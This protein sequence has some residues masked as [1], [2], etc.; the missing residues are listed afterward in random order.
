M[1]AAVRSIDHQPC[2]LTANSFITTSDRSPG[3]GTAGAERAIDRVLQLQPAAIDVVGDVHDFDHAARRADEGETLRSP[4]STCR[5]RCGWKAMP[6]PLSNESYL[7][8][9]RRWN[10]SLTAAKNDCE[11]CDATV[12][13]VRS[14]AKPNTCS[15]ALS[16]RSEIVTSGEKKFGTGPVGVGHHDRRGR[17]QSC[18]L[19]RTRPSSDC[20]WRPRRSCRSAASVATSRRS[21]ASASLP[22]AIAVRD[23]RSAES[24]RTRRS[25]PV[26]CPYGWSQMNSVSD[27]GDDG[28]VA[29]IAIES[30]LN[31]AYVRS[32]DL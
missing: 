4:A 19:H 14:S 10:G 29:P 27:C 8:C 13:P 9:K 1:S 21:T 7:P 12:P 28:S 32:V 18:G 6:A 26:F 3:I 24:C 5:R 11:P 22:P 30:T 2:G 20:R 23:R 31:I 15:D 25:T 16:V 17:R